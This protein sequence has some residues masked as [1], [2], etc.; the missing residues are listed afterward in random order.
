MTDRDRFLLI[1]LEDIKLADYEVRRI[2]TEMHKKIFNKVPVLDKFT[3][4]IKLE[5]PEGT[6]YPPVGGKPVTWKDVILYCGKVSAI[7]YIIG[8]RYEIV[9]TN[10]CSLVF[11]SNPF[12][13]I[14]EILKNDTDLL[15]QV[16]NLY[17]RMKKL[18]ELY[19]GKD[20]GLVDVV[21]HL[22]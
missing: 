11:D 13:E 5:T 9:Y 12:D 1:L 6:T 20:R 7:G 17:P 8:K 15:E 22:I 14:K 2:P 10:G 18:L 3:G 4:K 21:S 16:V 19:D